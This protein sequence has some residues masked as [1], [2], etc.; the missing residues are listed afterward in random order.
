MSKQFNKAI[1]KQRRQK[2]L[3]RRKTAAKAKIA[4]DWPA[5]VGS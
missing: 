1:K 3:K 5:K 4:T 2:Y